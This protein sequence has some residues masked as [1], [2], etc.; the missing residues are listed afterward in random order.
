MNRGTPNGILLRILS[1]HSDTDNDSS[2]HA[3]DEEELL[4]EAVD[5]YRCN[6][7]IT[8]FPGNL[9]EDGQKFGVGEKTTK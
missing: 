3:E 7:L 5:V 9:L 4:F 2:H 6:G 1:Q 8:N